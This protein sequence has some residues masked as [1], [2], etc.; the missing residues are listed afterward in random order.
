MAFG[1]PQILSAG[2]N[3]KTITRA[4]EN[5][6]RAT[7]VSLNRSTAQLKSTQV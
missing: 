4:A 1:A 3:R 5:E 6:V 2:G 7:L